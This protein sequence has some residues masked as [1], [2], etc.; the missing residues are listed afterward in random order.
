MNTKWKLLQNTT[1]L[2]SLTT[3]VAVACMGAAMAEPAEPRYMLN[4][5]EDAAYGEEILAGNYV[6]AIDKIKSTNRRSIDDYYAAVNLCAAR[7]LSR[8]FAGAEV[9]CDSAVLGAERLLQRPG[10]MSVH[11]FEARA[12]RRFMAMALSNR[13]V[14][15]ALQGEADLARDDFTKAMDIRTR[16]PAPAANLARLTKVEVPKV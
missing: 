1:A 7:V 9:A 13:G 12:Y 4:V 15:R 6:E 14:L 8:Q 5:I 16:L 3:V 11:S 10:H 2:R